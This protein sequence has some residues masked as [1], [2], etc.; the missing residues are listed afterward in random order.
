MESKQ[1]TL[2]IALILGVALLLAGCEDSAVNDK[3]IGGP[4][5]LAQMGLMRFG[6]DSTLIGAS[7]EERKAISERN[8]AFVDELYKALAGLSASEWQKAD[9]RVRSLLER[10][11]ETSTARAHAE[12]LASAAMLRVWLLPQN[13]S[14]RTQEARA[15]SAHYVSMLIDRRTPEAEL[16]ADGI[17]FVGDYWSDEQRSAKALAAADAARSYLDSTCP[18]CSRSTTLERSAPPDVFAAKTERAI[19]R[20]QN[21]IGVN[22][23]MDL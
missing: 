19:E 2:S 14:D 7:I 9:R 22:E 23:G 12:Q 13:E 11:D 4:S 20:L 1:R 6:T 5:A 10:I 17:A 21:I 8:M 18:E 16:I 15:A 3:D